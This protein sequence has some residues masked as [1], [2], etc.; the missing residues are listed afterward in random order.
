[1]SNI[2]PRIGTEPTIT[3]IATFATM[4][5]TVTYDTPRTQAATMMMQEAMPRDQI[6]NPRNEPDNAIEAESDR[7]AGNLDEVIQH[8][9]QQI[10][11][12][13]V[14]C[15]SAAFHPR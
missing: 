13:V 4:R 9:R 11:I 6:A 1:M 3:S 12:L 5:A 2:S 14:E 8:M 15:L 10:Q 7:G